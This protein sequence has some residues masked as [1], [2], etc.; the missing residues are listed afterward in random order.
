MV[1]VIEGKK[2]T[3]YSEQVRQMT[4]G[5]KRSEMWLGIMLVFNILGPENKSIQLLDLA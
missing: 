2:I 4:E 1:C 5:G 3:Q